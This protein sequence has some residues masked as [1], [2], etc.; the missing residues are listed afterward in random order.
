[1]SG[2][3][4]QIWFGTRAVRFDTGVAATGTG[5]QIEAITSNSGFATTTILG[6][7]NDVGWTNIQYQQLLAF[8]GTA[9]EQAA[10]G[11]NLANGVD[12][13][14]AGQANTTGDLRVG[15][16]VAAY[17]IA[18]MLGG[19]RVSNISGLADADDP[20]HV[21]GLGKANNNVLAA[22]AEAGTGPAN[23][24]TFSNDTGFGFISL[25]GAERVG[26]ASRLND[27]D[28][29]TFGVQ[30]SRFLKSA[31][32]T[33]KVLGDGSTDV[34][35]DSD[36]RTIRDVNGAEAG[37][38][39][40]DGSAGELNLGPLAHG[41]RVA[42]DFN[43][44]AITIDGVAFAGDTS[45]F[46][47]AYVANGRDHL[48]LGSAVVSDFGAVNTASTG[49]SVDD[50]V[51]TTT[52]TASG[53]PPLFGP[54]AP[55]LSFDLFGTSGDLPPTSSTTPGVTL[56]PQRLYAYTDD[57]GDNILNPGEVARAE[58][59]G[60]LRSGLESSD[61]PSGDGDDNPVQGRPVVPGGPDWID[62]YALGAKNLSSF[63]APSQLQYGE[64]ITGN[65]TTA[66]GRF[67]LSVDSARNNAVIT[68]GGP[69]GSPADIEAGNSPG[70]R[71][72]A[73]TPPNYVDLGE[74]LGF[75][76]KGKPATA[77]RIAY[78]DAL[79][80]TPGTSADIV[81]KLYSDGT[82]LKT[83]T[84][85]IAQMGALPAGAAP[86]AISTT[87]T[88]TGEAGSFTVQADLGTSFDRIEIQAAGAVNL[89]SIA[90]AGARF[91]LTD[92][93]FMLIA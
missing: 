14:L 2:T 52:D 15:G 67:A 44:L 53:A 58:D 87:A 62:M 75:V 84:Q 60:R 85:D 37:G 8:T 81:V 54:G 77:A 17:N 64:H 23:F 36:G 76:L 57:N 34:I 10:V 25:T 24:T 55:V 38:F 69:E 56:Q 6:Q 86:S 79:D 40:Q 12:T 88:G 78:G 29:V 72:F 50:L 4:T 16:G 27:G 35:L 18:D 66:P 89:V 73:D 21:N 33:V 90:D 13:A 3:I 48:T 5:H 49:W 70:G 11:I 74:T 83:V 39:V 82:L 30:G 92:L 28:S 19:N 43:T 7:T 51:L 61:D 41:T 22:G 46:F 9:A 20:V 32:F 65:W 63:A 31:S 93:D 26:N 45:G 1:M 42:V 80:F 71:T 68:G 91:V 47:A 59:L